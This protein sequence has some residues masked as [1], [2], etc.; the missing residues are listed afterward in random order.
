MRHVGIAVLVLCTVAACG[1]SSSPTSPSAAGGS[2]ATAPA[3][4]LQGQTIDVLTGAPAGNL[5]VVVGSY[6]PVTT[7]ANG[8]F[9]LDSAR[10]G[11]FPAA[12]SGP[13]IVPRDTTISPSADPMRV[14]VIPASFDMTAFDEMFRAENARLQR[15]T[16]RPSLVIIASTMALG[17]LSAET[18]V[19][20][21]EQMS[22]DEVN[23]LVAHLTEGLSLLTGG[24]F[25]SFASVD[26][27]RP[28]AGE[29]VTPMRSGRIT[30]GRYTGVVTAANTI[31]YGRWQAAGDGTVVG[32]GLFLD[33]DFDRNDARRRLLRIHELGH[34]LGYQH[35]KARPSIMNA[36]IGPEPTDFDRAGAR[37]AFQR[38]PGNRA[39][40]ADPAG[41]ARLSSVSESG[42]RWSD[43]SVCR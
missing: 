32:G 29:K 20:S 14:S 17:S 9:S 11:T 16:V 1:G 34:A 6:R 15:W 28:N 24:A 27:E 31:G 10:P 7:D 41:V 12:L 5:S 3:S 25:T 38:V 23:Q 36:S 26:V 37:I 2:S 21:S 42:G 39:P 43:P 18:F 19:A 30:V 4:G 8:M 35:V 13:G 22:A 33:R 40:D